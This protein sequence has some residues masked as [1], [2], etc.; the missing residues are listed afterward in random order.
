MGHLRSLTGRPGSAPRQARCSAPRAHHV[1]GGSSR[2]VDAAPEPPART[3]REAGHRIAPALSLASAFTLP[4]SVAAQATN[5]LHFSL[6]ASPGGAAQCMFCVPPFASGSRF[7]RG[8][9]AVVE[10]I[11]VDDCTVVTLRGIGD[12]N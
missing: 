4:V 11:G 1:R 2:G 3:R 10:S 7:T 9:R 8:D 6:S 5:A 12:D